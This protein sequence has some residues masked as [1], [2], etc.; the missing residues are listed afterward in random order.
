VS[1][2]GEVRD[3]SSDRKGSIWR[4]E[5]RRSGCADREQIGEGRSFRSVRGGL[6]AAEA[7]RLLLR[8]SFRVAWVSTFL[9]L[10]SISAFNAKDCALR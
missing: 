10:A 2:I 4:S 1:R 7:H 8:S 9:T 6:A 5:R 3:P